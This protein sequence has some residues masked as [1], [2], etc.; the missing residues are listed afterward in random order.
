MT[1][2]SSYEAAVYYDYTH[3]MGDVSLP[4]TE[5]VVDVDRYTLD[6]CR[7]GGDGTVEVLAREDEPGMRTTALDQLPQ[8]GRA[9]ILEEINRNMRRFYRTDGKK[10]GPACALLDSPLC[11]QLDQDFSSDA[12][13][14]DALLERGLKRLAELGISEE[15]IRILPIGELAAYYPAEFTL[16]RR[17]S[18]TP[19]LP[20][21]RFVVLGDPPGEI[22]RL[23]R[24]LYQ[25]NAGRN[26]VLVCIGLDGQTDEIV[27]AEKDSK[28]PQQPAYC[29][30]VFAAEPLQLRVDGNDRSVD[31]P[32]KVAGGDL[33]ELA[34]RLE[35]GG[36]ALL[37]RRTLSPKQIYEIPI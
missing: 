21:S 1:E 35:R 22:I 30:P 2:L 34:C 3:N 9:A 23:G 14:L 29:A 32:F 12:R 4:V 36:L 31:L 24:E 7:C 20:D 19:V 28:S 37:L 26:I 8:E 16:R 5:L 27:L 33:V 17:L 6:I 15:D 10:D 18:P 25:G 13:R 11:S